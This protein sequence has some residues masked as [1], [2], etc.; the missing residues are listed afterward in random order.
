MPSVAP[1]RDPLVK[2]RPW[3]K[4]ELLAVNEHVT[5]K[6]ITVAPGQ[7]LS[8]RKHTARDEWWT[9]LDDGLH[10]EVGDESCAPAVGERVW[11]PRGTVHRVTNRGATPARLLEI[12]FG[13]FDEADI[14]WLADDY[15][16]SSAHRP[17]DLL[18]RGPSLTVV[19]PSLNEKE[20]VRPLVD[21]LNKALS[22][23]DTEILYVDDSTDDTPQMVQSMAECSNLALRVVHREVPAGGLSGAVVEGIRRS[24]AEY[25]VVMDGD[26]QHPAE[27]VPRLLKTAVAT[28]SDVVIASRYLEDSDAGGLSSLWRR[29]VSVASTQIARVCFPRRVGR[30]CRDPM[31]GFFC[32]RRAALH[33]DRLHPRGYKILLEILAHH[34]L[35]VAEIPFAFGHRS[36]GSSKATW[37]N[38]I[39]YLR[40]VAC[41]RAGRMSRFA[42]VGALGT[43]VNLLTMSVLVHGAA[44]NYVL[45]AVLATEVAI[46]HN[47]LMQERFVF[48][49]C[50]HGVHSWASRLGLSFAF[51]NLEQIARL[52]LLVLLVSGLGL[53]S[54]AMQGLTLLLAF[55]ARFFFHS[56]VVYRCGAAA[57]GDTGVA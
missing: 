40:Q 7:R 47:F 14:D 30:L 16:R 42:M 34:D 21:R 57:S 54:V 49:D 25:V 2:N 41:L 27:L 26:L 4:S 37:K 3:G 1:M 56:K 53:Y 28:S 44:V 43:I 12:A 35:R 6:V 8:L 23:S 5:V 9:I 11:I 39:Q 55:F 13:R 22:G 33:L 50:K 38:G 18:R 29:S 19:I 48:K 10:T 20:N 24:R 52:P 15:G 45:A 51:N 31:T 36:G 17:A 46:L 32:V